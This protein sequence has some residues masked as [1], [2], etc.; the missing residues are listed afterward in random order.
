MGS[1]GGRALCLGQVACSFSARFAAQGLV[2]SDPAC[3]TGV[4]A[5]WISD[6]VHEVVCP[7]TSYSIYER[8]L[9]FPPILMLGL[10]FI[11]HS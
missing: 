1:V 8:A 9:D 2:S 5:P 4:C 3:M 6:I 11:K 7:L 10:S